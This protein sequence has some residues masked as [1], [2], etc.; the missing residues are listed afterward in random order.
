MSNEIALWLRKSWN[1]GLA[2][3]M[4]AHG[5]ADQPGTT[6][7][8]DPG[9]LNETEAPGRSEDAILFASDS[10][11]DLTYDELTDVDQE[12]VQK[13]TIHAIVRQSS[14]ESRSN[15]PNNV[16]DSSE[17][18]AGEESVEETVEVHTT[19][20]TLAFLKILPKCRTKFG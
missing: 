3:N 5:E 9:E 16:D 17:V 13:G 18:S 20:C 12:N 6:S 14:N 11:D 10:F 4:A 15:T 2:S 1:W 7:D 19:V 8:S